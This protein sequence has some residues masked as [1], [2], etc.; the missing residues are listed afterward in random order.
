MTELHISE[1]TLPSPIE[2]RGHQIIPKKTI[3]INQKVLPGSTTQ[4]GNTTVRNDTSWQVQLY[5]RERRLLRW[6][7]G[8]R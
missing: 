5:R 2:K 6:G 1:N 7:E 3:G 8:E 4:N